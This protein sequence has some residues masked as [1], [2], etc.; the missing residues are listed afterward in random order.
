MHVF[1]R[2]LAGTLHGAG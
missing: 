2:T 1:I